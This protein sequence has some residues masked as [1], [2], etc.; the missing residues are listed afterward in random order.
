VYLDRT[1]FIE[2][3]RSRA[4]LPDFM[5]SALATFPDVIEFAQALSASG[6]STSW[7]HNNE[8]RELNYDR[9]EKY[10]LRKIFRLFVSSF[11]RRAQARARHHTAR[12]GDDP[13]AA[14][15]VLF[16][17]DRALNLECAVK[18]GMKAIAMRTSS[19]CVRIWQNWR[20]CLGTRHCL[21]M[22]DRREPA[23]SWS[24]GRCPLI[25]FGLARL[26]GANW[27]AGGISDST[28]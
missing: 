19:S 12:I 11:R 27:G 16:I 8:S 15:S 6:A 7:D 25:N 3:A 4:R 13:D 9:I 5:Y 17:D 28:W 2:R 18:L 21:K 23:L 22:P 14:R 10:G 1:V 24:N 20:E 26:G